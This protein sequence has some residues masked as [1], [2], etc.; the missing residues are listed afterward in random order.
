MGN[1]HN[2]DKILNYQKWKRSNKELTD[3]FFVN[4]MKSYFNFL[5]NII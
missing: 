4:K 5:M 1:H 2:F 3:Y